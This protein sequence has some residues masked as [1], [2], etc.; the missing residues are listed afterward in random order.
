MV[1]QQNQQQTQ[2]LSL[3]TSQGASLL[4]VFHWGRAPPQPLTEFPSILSWLPCRA[5]GHNHDCVAP[6]STSLQFS[7]TEQGV[8]Q[9]AAVL[10]SLVPIAP[11]AT[12]PGC[13][14]S[15][16]PVLCS[17]LPCC[18]LLCRGCGLSG[19]LLP[20]PHAVFTTLSPEPTNAT[21]I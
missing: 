2:S 6:W 16:V 11:S 20:P 8:A 9:I 17:H 15:S 5:L 21:F 18:W 14:C 4:Y 3:P 7:F 1:W 12:K 19:A 10:S 13:F